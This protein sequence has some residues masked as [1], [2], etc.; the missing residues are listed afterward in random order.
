MTRRIKASEFKAKCLAI[1]DEVERTGEVVVITKNGRPV[2]ELVPHLPSR[3]KLLG[4][5]KDRLFITG[6]I[7]SPMDVDWEALE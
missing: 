5:L 6:D 7:I 3:P 2:A 1:M 4:L